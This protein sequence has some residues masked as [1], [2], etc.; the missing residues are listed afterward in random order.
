MKRLDLYY[1]LFSARALFIAGILIMP[2]LL[3]NPSTEFRVFQFL[4]FLVLAFLCGKRTNPVLTLLIIIFI[5]T[6]NLFVPYGYVLYSFGGFKITSGALT[7]GVHRAFTLSALVMLSKVTIRED[8]RIPGAFGEILGES[9][10]I[11]SILMNRKIR[12][13]GKNVILEI[14]SLMLEL[15][16]ETKSQETSLEVLKTK[17][18]P[19]GYVIVIIVFILSWLPWFLRSDNFLCIFQN[20]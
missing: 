20:C 17:T 8:L 5:V 3:F 12:I 4:F 14:D 10:R 16:K 13:T 11:F 18:K 15:S 9:L 19:L 2:A 6:F 7:A 1:N